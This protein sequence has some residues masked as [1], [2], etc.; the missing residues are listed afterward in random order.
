[1]KLRKWWDIVISV[2]L[3]GC[4]RKSMEQPRITIKKFKTRSEKRR[5]TNRTKFVMCIFLL[6][7]IRKSDFFSNV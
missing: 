3:S 1:M 4:L 2:T 6:F 7:C 5:K